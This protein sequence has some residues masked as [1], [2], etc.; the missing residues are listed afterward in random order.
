VLLA[1]QDRSRWR[2]DDIG[3]GLDL[4][5]EALR[6]SGAGPGPWTVQAAI[7]ALH[8]HPDPDRAAIVTLYDRLAA[9]TP[10]SAVLV[11]R[12]AAI[13]RAQ[14]PAAGLAAL[15]TI[16]TA[17]GDHRASVLRAELHAELGQFAEARHQMTLAVAATRNDVER[18]HLR[19][20]LDGW[21]T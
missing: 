9:L 4:A 6:R 21:S 10:S 15:D 2:W 1:D 20:R 3:R 16:T 18:R 19:A 13:A 11:N 5:A 14:G 8:T 12:A 17:P 7:A